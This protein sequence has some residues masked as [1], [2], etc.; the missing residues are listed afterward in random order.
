MRYIMCRRVTPQQ[1]RHLAEKEPR[2]PLPPR[3]AGRSQPKMQ[4]AAPPSP[5]SVR[6]LQL[7]LPRAAGRAVRPP[8]RPTPR[9]PLYH[10]LTMMVLSPLPA[11]ITR[12]PAS[13]A[14]PGRR[15]VVP[16]RGDH[17]LLRLPHHAA[18]MGQPRRPGGSRS[19]PS[20]PL[21]LLPLR[22]HQIKGQRPSVSVHT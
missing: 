3:G 2:A 19:L 14:G 20:L 7:L 11:P 6:G 22:R 18:P 9:L 8:R 17:P 13:E 12:G 15:T 4:W 5:R 10:R 1:G 21:L 16:R